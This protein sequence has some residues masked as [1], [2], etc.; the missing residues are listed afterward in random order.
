[1]SAVKIPV[2]M[3]KNR[4]RGNSVG[5]MIGVNRGDPMDYLLL[6]RSTLRDEAL[7]QGFTPDAEWLTRG[8]RSLLDSFESAYRRWTDNKDGTVGFVHE[9]LLPSGKIILMGESAVLL[10][11][12]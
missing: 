2:V 4:L 8:V 10:R 6:V 3:G 7:A 1:M 11:I 12:A 5:A 9:M